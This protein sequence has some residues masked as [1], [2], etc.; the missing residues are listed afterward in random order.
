MQNTEAE[1][2]ITESEN[3]ECFS[4]KEARQKAT[5]QL[6]GQTRDTY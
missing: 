2:R 5:G 4:G 6:R 1:H 3:R